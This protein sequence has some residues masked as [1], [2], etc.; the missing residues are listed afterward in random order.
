[1]VSRA[2]A[3]EFDAAGAVHL[4]SADGQK[5]GVCKTLSAD[6]KEVRLYCHSPGRE[7]KER[8]I[9]G[10]FVERFEAGLTKLSQGL[11]KPRTQKCK[12]RIL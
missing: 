11:N 1:M 3:R 10:R 12:A 8:A 5:I 2:G 6:G 4:D 7:H 9:S